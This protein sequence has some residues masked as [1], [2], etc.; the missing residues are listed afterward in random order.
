MIQ[1]KAGYLIRQVINQMTRSSYF[2]IL[3]VKTVLHLELF[4]FILIFLFFL[5]PS[6]P[7]LNKHI[8]YVYFMERLDRWDKR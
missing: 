5:P 6:H 1:C 8:K 3:R 2:M 7:P 4:L